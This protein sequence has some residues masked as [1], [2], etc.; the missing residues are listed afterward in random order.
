MQIAR[1]AHARKYNYI[2]IKPG[3]K[4]YSYLDPRPSK[5]ENQIQYKILYILKTKQKQNLQIHVVA[6]YKV[7]INIARILAL[8]SSETSVVSDGREEDLTS[9]Y[10]FDK[11]TEASLLTPSPPPLAFD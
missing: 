5:I 2:L 6:A 8:R 3:T 11:S 1:A 4:I 9:L 7:A 10:D